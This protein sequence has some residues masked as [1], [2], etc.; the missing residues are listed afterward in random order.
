M[1]VFEGERVRDLNVFT[2][3]TVLGLLMSCR[4]ESIS[5]LI[6]F[7][8]VP[9][10]LIVAFCANRGREGLRCDCEMLLVSAECESPPAS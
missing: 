8:A 6:D 9:S 5:A 7:I 3:Q 1:C 4:G 10:G 2:L